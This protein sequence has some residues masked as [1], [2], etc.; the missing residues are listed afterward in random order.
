MGAVWA[1]SG[2][3]ASPAAGPAV[4][5]HAACDTLDRF[6]ESDYGSSDEDAGEKVLYHWGAAHSLAEAAAIG[7]PNYEPLAKAIR[8]SLNQTRRVFEV[9]AKAER[10][11]AKA[12]EICSSL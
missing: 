2:N 12:R 3:S 7:D 1:V 4:D 9:D 8:D 10:D 5:A 6:D 11:L